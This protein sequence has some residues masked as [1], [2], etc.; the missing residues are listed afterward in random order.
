MLH[1]NKDIADAYPVTTAFERQY[2][3]G[4]YYINTLK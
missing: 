1:A 2:F 4:Y 3:F